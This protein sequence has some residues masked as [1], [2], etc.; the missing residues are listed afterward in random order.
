M[1]APNACGGKGFADG[2][3]AQP[4]SSMP[5]ITAQTITH[6]LNNS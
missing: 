3:M 6:T 4:L 1:I 5:S 2:N